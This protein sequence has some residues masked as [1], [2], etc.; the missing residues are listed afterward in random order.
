VTRFIDENRAGFG[1]EPICRTLEVSASAYYQRNTGQRSARQVH[2]KRLLDVIQT[3]HKNNFEAYGRTSTDVKHTKT[4][5]SQCEQGFWASVA[6]RSVC[7][8]RS[9]AIPPW[10][11]AR[12]RRSGVA[13]AA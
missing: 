11:R 9:E 8:R 2:D 1:V 12:S 4:V 5:K 13:R 6:D 10:W 7:L 3:T